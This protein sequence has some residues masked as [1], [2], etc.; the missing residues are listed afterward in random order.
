MTRTNERAH[1]P[2]VFSFVSRLL[3]DQSNSPHFR[4]YSTFKTETTFGK[5]DLRDQVRRIILSGTRPVRR[6]KLT[7][8]LRS[9]LFAK[10]QIDLGPERPPHRNA[11]P[12]APLFLNLQGPNQWL[13]EEIL[14]GFSESSLVDLP[15]VVSFDPLASTS[16]T[17][18]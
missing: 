1:L 12:T 2:S 13:P 5:S 14:P 11:S 7:S 8:L 4:G 18:G 6:P 9:L 10:S 17:E 15:R 16:K 3:I